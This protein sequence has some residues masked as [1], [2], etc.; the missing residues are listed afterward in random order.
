MQLPPNIMQQYLG[1]N[2]QPNQTLD[3]DIVNRS[4]KTVE[5]RFRPVEMKTHN[6][7]VDSMKSY[8]HMLSKDQ[9]TLIKFAAKLRSFA[10]DTPDVH[11]D[12]KSERMRIIDRNSNQL[13][14]AAMLNI[15]RATGGAT[16]SIQ[17]MT[18]RREIAQALAGSIEAHVRNSLNTVN[19]SIGQ[20]ANINT[21]EA[22]IKGLTACLG[23]MDDLETKISNLEI[24]I[25]RVVIDPHKQAT[26]ISAADQA[27]LKEAQYGGTQK[28]YGELQQRLDNVRGR[29]EEIKAT[30]AAL[31]ERSQS[32][33]APPPHRELEAR[34][35]AIKK[36]ARPDY[37]GKIMALE[38]EL[39]GL[40]QE[41]KVLSSIGPARELSDNNQRLISL[42]AELGTAKSEL[43][44][45]IAL[46]AEDAP[47]AAQ[48]GKFLKTL[49]GDYKSAILLLKNFKKFG[50]DVQNSQIE[51]GLQK[52]F[53][54]LY[55][56]LQTSLTKV[57]EVR[58]RLDHILG[59]MNKL[60]AKKIDASSPEFGAALEAKQKL[61]SEYQM[62]K[63][64]A[65]EHFKA[66][67]TFST[68]IF[69]PRDTEMGRVPTA[70]DFLIGIND[71]TKVMGGKLSSKENEWDKSNTHN[72]VNSR[73]LLLKQTGELFKK[74]QGI[75]T[76]FKNVSSIRSPDSKFAQA[77]SN[78]GAEITKVA[79]TL[80]QLDNDTSALAEK[81]DANI[82]K[83]KTATRE[84]HSEIKRNTENL[85]AEANQA[86]EWGEGLSTAL[87]YVKAMDKH[88]QRVAQLIA[89]SNE[90]E[91]RDELGKEYHQIA[92]DLENGQ[93]RLQEIKLKFALNMKED[94]EMPQDLKD[95]TEQ[96]I[97]EW[98]RRLTA[99]QA[100]I[101]NEELKQRLD[102]HR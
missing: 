16:P 20:S 10:N 97:N 78:I 26:P 87:A 94:K 55:D 95:L 32:A 52:T 90:T 40:E 79:A 7:G 96:T 59:E 74:V 92:F 17:N 47:K 71:V 85:L 64:E 54:S 80:R 37:K 14:N 21:A 65:T 11:T 18:D 28:T 43:K 45:Q 93:R 61:F 36:E 100:Q 56:T 2:L 24:G 3:A 44:K 6:V 98:E 9:E 4:D 72:Y 23:R 48:D 63:E 88:E 86:K 15:A 102:V 99:A 69:N 25:S 58:G 82:P 75:R 51:K 34:S 12:G 49:E 31:K 84:A 68:L 33:P 19:A 38:K 101:N 42:K 73:G 60:E 13:F 22:K 41:I 50:M 27:K 8:G 76:F 77:Y 39:V 81:G 29:Q 57:Q 70:K 35:G 83:L 66:L 91:K 30:L 1:V 46:F 89:R 53:Q 5:G 67:Q 62:V